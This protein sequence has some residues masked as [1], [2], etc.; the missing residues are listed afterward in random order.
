MQSINLEGLGWN[1]QDRG[2]GHRFLWPVGMG[3]RPAESDEKSELP[4]SQLFA[5]SFALFRGPFV[6]NGLV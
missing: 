3:L 5:Q 1:Y 6:F 4:L 2:A